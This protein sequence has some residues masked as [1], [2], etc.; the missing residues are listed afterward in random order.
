MKELEDLKIRL[1]E[2]FEGWIDGCFPL[3]GED[4]M[5]LKQAVKTSNNILLETLI[6]KSILHGKELQKEESKEFLK[7]SEN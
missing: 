2:S 1:Q 3:N 4:S 6:I 5:G 7:P